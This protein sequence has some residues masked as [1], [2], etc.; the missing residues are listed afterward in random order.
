MRLYSNFFE[1][2]DAFGAAG[3]GRAYIV[4]LGYV[5]GLLAAAKAE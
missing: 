1:R 4:L 3:A 5:S 2:G